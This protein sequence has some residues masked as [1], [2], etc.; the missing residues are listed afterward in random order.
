MNVWVGLVVGR[1]VR[2]TFLPPE[3]FLVAV[4]ANGGGGDSVVRLEHLLDGVVEGSIQTAL[5]VKRVLFTLST[6]TI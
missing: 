6:C 4:P 2:E 3:E 1:L 5:P